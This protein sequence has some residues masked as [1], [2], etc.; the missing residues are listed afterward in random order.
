MRRGSIS[1]RLGTANAGTCQLSWF[2]HSDYRGSL[3]SL[4]NPL[5]PS[6]SGFLARNCWA[7]FNAGRLCVVADSSVDDQTATPRNNVNAI[8]CS[9]R[10][11]LRDPAA[12]EQA[13]SEVS[14]QLHSLA[15]IHPRSDSITYRPRS[16]VRGSQKRG[17]VAGIDARFQ[18]QNLNTVSIGIHLGLAKLQRTHL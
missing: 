18:R 16:S 7:L 10:I 1:V 15:S 2:R 5:S 8:R 11:D 17:S 9:G 12:S 13:S 3:V 14:S 6:P 4:L